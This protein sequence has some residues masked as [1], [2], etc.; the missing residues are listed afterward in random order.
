MCGLVGCAGNIS[1]KQEKAFS[2]LLILDGLRGIDSTGMAA[3]SK[4]YS[5]DIMLAKQVGNPYELIQHPVFNKAMQRVNRVFI[6]HNR[7]ATQ[8]KVNKINAHPYEFDKL[9]GAHN[10][11]LHAKHNLLDHRDFDVDSMNLYHHIN[12]KGLNDVLKVMEGAWALTWWDKDEET[13]NFLRNKERPLFMTMTKT[14]TLFWASEQWMLE[15][16]LSRNDLEFEKIT[17]LPED[18]H[19][20]FLIDT[21]GNVGKPHAV[22]AKA[23]KKSSTFPAWATGNVNVGS[24][25]N[26]QIHSNVVPIDSKNTGVAPTTATALVAG[27]SPSHV[28]SLKVGDKSKDRSG[29]E[30]YWCE[31]FLNKDKKLRLYIKSTDRITLTGKFI[32]AS[33]HQYRFSDALGLYYKVQHSSV[34]LLNPEPETKEEID[35]GKPFYHNSKGRLIPKDQWEEEHGIC[36]MCTGYV[37][38]ELEF[39][40]TV[41]G[42]VLCHECAHD[43]MTKMYVNFR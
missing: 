43:P 10:G 13:V 8:G 39:K 33:M 17:S 41:D 36:A 30:F 37:N 40:F 2:H 14:G 1:A 29:N 32:S 9:V 21:Q 7:Y 31:D 38:P 12:E 28:I 18:I 35:E 11:T 34:R 15:V 20:S 16:A 26:A 42:E 5:H 25:Q 27:Y 6:G 4:F 3:V 22:E 23:S 19:L 24:S